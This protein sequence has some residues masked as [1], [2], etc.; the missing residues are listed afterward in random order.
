MDPDGSLETGNTKVSSSKKRVSSSKNWCFTFNNYLTKDIEYLRFFFEEHCSKWFFAEEV[1]AE[2]TP[3]LQGFIEFKKKCRPVE[4]CK[5]YKCIHWEKQKGDDL[6]NILYCSKEWRQFYKSSNIRIIKELNLISKLKPWQQ[7][8]YNLVEPQ[9]VDDRSVYWFYDMDGNMGKTA[10]T[11]Y[12][13]AKLN[14]VL[15]DGDKKDVLFNASQC[16]TSDI[17]IFNFSRSMEKRISYDA[18]EKIKDGIYAQEKYESKMILRNAPHVIIFANWLPN[19]NKLSKDRWKIQNLQDLEK[20]LEIRQIM[21]DDLKR[22]VAE[23]R[24]KSLNEIL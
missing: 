6:Q 21:R 24:V 16:P 11:K 20:D 3:H 17:F 9:C 22:E 18:I 12:L 10:L 4:T 23:P 14:A 1:G 2:G 8:I 13:C 19:M 5:Q 7:Y 15:V